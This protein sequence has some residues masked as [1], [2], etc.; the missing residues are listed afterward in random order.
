MILKLSKVL[1]FLIV[2][3]LFWATTTSNAQIHCGDV[4]IT[5]D[6]TVNSL[7]VFDNFTNYQSGITI[8]SV[9]RIRVTVEDKNTPDP[10]CS[11]SLRMF[12]DN[13]SG[14]GTP[15]TEWEEITTYGNGNGQ[16]PLINSL[17]IRVRNSCTTSPSDGIYRSF[18]DANDI[19]D[20]IEQM[21]PVTPAGS[22]TDNINGAGSYLTNY[23][24]FNFN[25]DIRFKPDFS[26]NPGIFKLN[27]R[28][29]LSENL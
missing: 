16:N 18:T 12:I 5:P 20:I 19:L 29:L 17:E 25:V 8:N 6:T 11:W 9:T 13:N 26:F 10:L 2:V 28:F 23:N 4:S 7:M 21:L 15:P 3:V 14:A 24:E 22:C 1:N 27:I